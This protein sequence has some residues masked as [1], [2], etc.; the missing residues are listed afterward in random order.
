MA[1]GTVGT[2]GDNL[3]VQLPAE[4]VR[5]AGLRDGEHVEIEARD[6]VIV[7][8]HA[9]ARPTLEEL[10]G[11]RNPENWRADYADAHDWGPDVGREVVAE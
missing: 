2:W 11:G 9:K 6:G 1:Q 8:R 4:V 5:V 3:A 7:I 10:F